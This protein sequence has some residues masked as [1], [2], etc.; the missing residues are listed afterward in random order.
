[1]DIWMSTWAWRMD[2]QMSAD[3]CFVQI[4]YINVALCLCSTWCITAQDECSPG[5]RLVYFV[6]TYHF[7][8]CR[9]GFFWCIQFSVW[10]SLFHC[11]HLAVHLSCLLE[12]SSTSPLPITA[13][14]WE[15]F[16][17]LYMQLGSV[18]RS[19]SPSYI[20]RK[21]KRDVGGAFLGPMGTNMSARAIE[22]GIGSAILQNFCL[23]VCGCFVACLPKCL[24]QNQYQSGQL[25][26]FA[27]VRI[28]VWYRVVSSMRDYVTVC[29]RYGS[30]KQM[31][32]GTIWDFTPWL[33]SS[34]THRNVHPSSQIWEEFGRPLSALNGSRLRD[35]RMW[36]VYNHYNYILDQRCLTSLES[37]SNLFRCS[38]SWFPSDMS[39]T[40]A[41]A[42]HSTLWYAVK[43]SCGH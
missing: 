20:W 32:V 22:M 18:F 11:H 33:A 7:L 3:N 43:R 1:M 24:D 30:A 14:D 23:K 9:L 10:M 34:L 42:H 31:K 29:W 27:L 25:L 38:R 8:I 37:Q 2:M 17:C 21:Q 12:V 15:T 16:V 35:R 19:V 28:T 40:R 41:C 5:R 36:L 26:G 39:F 13:T 6:H 4:Q